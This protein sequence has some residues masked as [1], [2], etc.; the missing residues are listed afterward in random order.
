MQSGSSGGIHSYHERPKVESI[1]ES[2]LDINHDSWIVRIIVDTT[3]SL[4]V[5]NL[6]MSRQGYLLSSLVACMD[7][8]VLDFFSSRMSREAANMRYLGSLVLSSVV[9][10]PGALF[11]SEETS[12]QIGQSCSSER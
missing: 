12:V 6:L 5:R 2:V 11:S 7:E 8:G 1:R 4:S 3:A 10:T 9:M